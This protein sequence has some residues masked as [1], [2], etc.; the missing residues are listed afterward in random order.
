MAHWR[1]I[2][3]ASAALG[4]TVAAGGAAAV[5]ERIAAFLAE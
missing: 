4:M 5:G 3:A 1:L 2:L